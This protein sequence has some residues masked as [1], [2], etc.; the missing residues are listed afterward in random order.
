[1]T[2]P[3]P[4]REPSDQGPAPGRD[5][6]CPICAG[7]APVDADHTPFCSERCKLADLGNWFSGRYVISRE[8]SLEDFDDPDTTIVRDDPDERK[9]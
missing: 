4:P 1:M 6:R 5:V 2:A 7:P 9:D 8:A 3:E